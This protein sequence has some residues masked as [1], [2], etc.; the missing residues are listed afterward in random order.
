MRSVHGRNILWTSETAARTALSV[1]S[2]SD[3][4]SARPSYDLLEASGENSRFRAAKMRPVARSIV[5]TDALRKARVRE[6]YTG[7]VYCLRLSST[8]VSL[9]C[10]RSLWVAHRCV[11]TKTRTDGPMILPSSAAVD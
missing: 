4:N 1:R 3:G 11:F 9:S 2:N 5:W 8:R 10:S 7:T 6:M